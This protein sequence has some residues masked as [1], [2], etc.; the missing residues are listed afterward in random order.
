VNCAVTTTWCTTRGVFVDVC[1]SVCRWRGG[2]GRG[3]KH[4]HTYFSYFLQKCVGTSPA[5]LW[6]WTTRARGPTLTTKSI[7][8]HVGRE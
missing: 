8:C 7:W 6:T 3:E 4:Q 1:V 2:G 5:V